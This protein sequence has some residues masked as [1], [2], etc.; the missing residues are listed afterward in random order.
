MMEE[1]HLFSGNV[2]ICLRP[3]FEEIDS[4]F[5]CVRQLPD[6]LMSLEKT[7]Y[8]KV[9]GLSTNAFGLYGPYQANA[10]S[11][12]FITVSLSV[13]RSFRLLPRKRSLGPSSSIFWA[14]LQ[15]VRA[16]PVCKGAYGALWHWTDGIHRS[17]TP[18]HQYRQLRIAPFMFIDDGCFIAS[19]EPELESRDDLPISSKSVRAGFDRYVCLWTMPRRRCIRKIGFR[20]LTVLIFWDSRHLIL[21]PLLSALSGSAMLFIPLEQWLHSFQRLPCNRIELPEKCSDFPLSFT[22]HEQAVVVR[23]ADIYQ[24]LTLVWLARNRPLKVPTM[25]GTF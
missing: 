25:A 7:I 3:I 15:A 10:C 1:C 18:A 6:S 24:P 5:V 21:S 23:P 19:A 20:R 13:F 22:V 12:C 8:R 2:W 9:L 14:F 17:S 16:R 4:R 11:S